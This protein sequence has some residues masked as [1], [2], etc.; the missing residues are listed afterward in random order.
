MH[1][2]LRKLV[3]ITALSTLLVAPGAFAEEMDHGTLAAAVRSADFPCNHV[4]SVTE[5]AANTWSVQCN[6]G[7]YEV[8]RDEV[9]SS[10]GH[11]GFQWTVTHK[12]IKGPGE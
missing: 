1:Y 3:T 4:I 2:R 9:S 11:A 6:A 7:T 8:T 12:T 5:S 10:K